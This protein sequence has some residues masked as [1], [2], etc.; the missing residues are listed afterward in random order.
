VND[1]EFN[2]LDEPWI[3]VIDEACEIHEV[4]LPELFEHAHDYRDLCGELPTQDF[5]M[6][7]LLLAVLH[8]VF[9]RYD[10]KGDELPL[11]HPDEAME[12]WQELWE[13]RRFPARI[14]TEY[15]ESQRENFYLFHPE[16]PFYQCE[17]AKAGTEYS[18][19]K[20]NGNLSESSNKVRLFTDISGRA[21]EEMSFAEAARWLLYVNAYDDTSAKPSRESKEKGLKLPSTG[22]GW[23][24]K[25]G[26]IFVSGDNLFETLMLNLIMLDER[27][28]LF[29]KEN[30]VWERKE[31]PDGERVQISFPDNLS[32]LYTLQSRRLYLK[33]EDQRVTGYF[34]LGGDFFDREC[35]T[36]SG[37]VEPMTV[38]KNPDNK[39]TDIYI[40]WRHNE[41]KQFWKECSAAILGDEGNR[42]PGIISWIKY[43]EGEGWIRNYDLNVRIVSVQYGDKDFFVTNVF[44]DS[45]Q[46]HASL[47]SDMNARWKKA[48]L[49]SIEFCDDIAKKVWMLAKDVNLAAGGSDRTK[50]SKGTS[51]V[52]A[53]HV[54][55]GFYN[56]VDGPFRR[57]L[58][59][60]TPEADCDDELSNKRIQWRRECVEIARQM[61]KELIS[62]ADTAAIFG[63]T[64]SGSEGEKK[65]ETLSAASAMNRFLNVLK[66]K[67]E[68]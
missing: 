9:S 50:E 7:R 16:R 24:G 34:L 21:K 22:V 40:P 51:S 49:D 25:L 6:L 4:S 29:E 1:K 2:L 64:K 14:I 47:L 67:E 44:S 11:D 68:S 31:I 8:T 19:S 56:R 30:P 59:G 63:R 54:K 12:R 38:W 35:K 55:A 42:Q 10:V 18:A 17:H 61:G 43:L 60:L 26:I 23:L 45:L 41:S 46:M 57:W 37:L 65:S 33:K 27:K 36:G 13:S 53:D 48:V 15:L 32:E 66:A 28:E 62:Q 20:L 5:A 58:Y 3:R 39:K 52:F